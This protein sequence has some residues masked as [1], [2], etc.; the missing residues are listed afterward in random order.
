MH[1]RNSIEQEHW[2]IKNQIV[3][4]GCNELLR[5]LSHGEDTLFYGRVLIYLFRCFPLCHKS[6]INL[7]GEFNV[8][9]TTIYDSS[10]ANPTQINEAMEV[11]E[12]KVN[13]DPEPSA[14]EAKITITPADQSSSNGK[15]I[16]EKKLSGEKEEK[17]KALDLDSL[18]SMFWS[19]Q[20]YFS[21]PT[22]LFK[23]ENLKLFKEG[24]EAT[25]LKFKEVQKDQDSRASVKSSDEPKQGTKRKRQAD[26][27]DLVGELNPKYLTSKDLFALEVRNAA[28]PYTLSGLSNNISDQ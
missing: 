21:Q 7:R 6:A 23:P 27:Q 2:R 18:Y 14:T 13:G 24:L 8:D 3:L 1:T 12:P 16:G 19:L 4:R 15:D 5:R 9:N 20:N 28:N 25:I 22:H 10:P 11:D 26:E 17:E